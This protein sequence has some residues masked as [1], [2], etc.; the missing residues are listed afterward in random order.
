MNQIYDKE[1]I[2]AK[3]IR[4]E[5]LSDALYEDEL[6]LIIK[7]KYPD[8]RY[9]THLLCLPKGEYTNFHE[10][11]THHNKIHAFFQKIKDILQKINIEHYQLSTNNGDRAGQEIMHFHIHI[12]SNDE[13]N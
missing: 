13:L 7:D 6:L 8:K 11:I 3:I 2:F 12:K 5:I 4:K 9:K 10:F 1:N